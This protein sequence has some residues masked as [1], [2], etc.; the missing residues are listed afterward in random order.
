MSE[1]STFAASLEVEERS[2]AFSDL[3]ALVTE[4]AGRAGCALPECLEATIANFDAQEGTTGSLVE[5]ARVEPLALA[6]IGATLDLP[7]GADIDDLQAA[8]DARSAAEQQSIIDT[9]VEFV[10]NAKRDIIREAVSNSL[11]ELGYRRDGVGAACETFVHKDGTSA[12]VNLSTRGRETGINLELGGF[13]DG[14]C[15]RVRAEIVQ[16]LKGRGIKLRT[17]VRTDVPM[18]AY[19]A[20]IRKDSRQSERSR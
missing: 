11:L 20:C 7:A 13:S 17:I 6:R 5:R 10:R 14:R 12:R 8:L 9:A 1:V 15:R 16:S 3:I 4:Q 19:D 2:A 18:A